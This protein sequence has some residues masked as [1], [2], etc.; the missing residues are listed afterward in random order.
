MTVR[1]LQGQLGFL[2]QNPWVLSTLLPYNIKGSSL[3]R[4]TSTQEVPLVAS[5]HCCD[6]ICN[7]NSLSSQ[8]VCTGTV[9]HDRKSER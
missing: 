5:F 2:A 6:K 8:E 4:I 1:E 3:D 9:Y 7:E